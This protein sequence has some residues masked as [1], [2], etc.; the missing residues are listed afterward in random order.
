MLKCSWW[1][2]KGGRGGGAGIRKRARRRNPPQF[3][4]K[5]SEKTVISDF[6]TEI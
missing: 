2:E 3:T 6:S 5:R 1:G 4:H